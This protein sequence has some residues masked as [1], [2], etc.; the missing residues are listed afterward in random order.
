MNLDRAVLA[1][2]GVMILASVALAHFV[3][4]SWL[5]LTAFVG[6]NLLQ[7]SFTGFCPAA[8]V[9]RRLGVPGG[10]AFK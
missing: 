3:S 8:L 10:C 5:W 9:F 7:A 6:L 4:P 2:A 1:F